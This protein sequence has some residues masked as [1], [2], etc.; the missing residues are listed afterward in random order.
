MRSGKANLRELLDK[1]TTGK[2]SKGVEGAST[3][4]KTLEELSAGFGGAAVEQELQLQRPAAADLA[5]KRP[6]RGMLS[7]DGAF[8]AGA[9]V[10]LLAVGIVLSMVQQRRRAAAAPAGLLSGV[11]A[12]T[13]PVPAG[14]HRLAS[15]VPGV[16]ERF[17]PELTEVVEQTGSPY[18]ARRRVRTAF[19]ASGPDSRSS[20]PQRSPKKRH[21]G[22]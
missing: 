8:A 3:K 18:S 12:A 4:R 7:F 15:L 2:P 13:H 11:S 9:A 14:S 19:N 22:M 5:A 1:Y 6:S 10:V 21:G 17:A 20:S 16:K